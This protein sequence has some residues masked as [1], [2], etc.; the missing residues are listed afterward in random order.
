MM[1]PPPVSSETTTESRRSDYPAPTVEE[2]TNTRTTYSP[3]GVRHSENREK[4]T[5]PAMEIVKISLDRKDN[6]EG[7]KSEFLASWLRI[8]AGAG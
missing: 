6:D 1:N 5:T 4:T 2:K 3:F 8:E 7:W